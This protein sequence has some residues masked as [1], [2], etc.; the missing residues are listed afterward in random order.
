V[1]DA[2]GYYPITNKLT[3]VGRVQGGN[4]EGWGGDDVRMTDL[5]FKGGETIRGFK[6]AG[7]GPRD[8]CEDPVTGERVHPLLRRIPSAARSTGRPPRATFPVP[9]HSRQ[10][11]HAGRRIRRRGLSV[12]IPA[13]LR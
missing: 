11:W 4:I 7:I 13:T 1:A 2:R 12:S 8:A 3:L 5:F 9:V 10:S 6:R